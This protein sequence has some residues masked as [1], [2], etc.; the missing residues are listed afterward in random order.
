MELVNREDGFLDIS[1]FKLH[2]ELY[3]IINGVKYYFKECKDVKNVYN[4][5]IAEE[6]AKDFG[7]NCAHYDL[8]IRDDMI[9]VISEDIF[10][11]YDGIIAED[12]LNGYFKYKNT[13][14]LRFKNNIEE[15]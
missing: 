3:V 15:L 1:K 7:I 9:G 4:E 12:F 2:N 13:S 8:A 10:S 5:L 11:K 14:D 6:L